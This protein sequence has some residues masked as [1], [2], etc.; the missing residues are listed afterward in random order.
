[1]FL[2]EELVSYL[3]NE[4]GETDRLRLEAHLAGCRLCTDDFAHLSESHYSV[5]EWR[6]SEFANIE[7]PEFS[8]HGNILRSGK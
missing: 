2:P 4:A 6:R 3:Y 8:A 1:M 5:Y 7:T